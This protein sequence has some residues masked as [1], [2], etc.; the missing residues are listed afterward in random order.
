MNIF[1]AI[2]LYKK[3]KKAKKETQELVNKIPVAKVQ[4]AFQKWV[5][6]TIDLVN[7][8]TPLKDIALD[9]IGYV[10]KCFLKED[11]QKH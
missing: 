1:E 10:K 2:R 11:A 8:L 7:V 6:A 9:L 4:T 5:D 3:Y